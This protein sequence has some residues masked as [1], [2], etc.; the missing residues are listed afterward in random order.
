M[1]IEKFGLLFLINYFNQLGNVKNHVLLA[2]KEVI[3]AMQSSFDIVRQSLA[4]SVLGTNLEFVA[5]LMNHVQSL[6]DYS[7]TK[8]T[9]AELEDERAA[10]EEGSSLKDHIV[11]SIVSAIDEEIENTQGTLTEKNRLKVEALQTVKQVL[12]NQRGRPLTDPPTEA[13]SD[14]IIPSK[15]LGAA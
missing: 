6:L 4:K 2:L 11:S 9:P 8:V 1:Q 15:K 7:I 10:T 3:L 13:A 5:S 12:L 14:R